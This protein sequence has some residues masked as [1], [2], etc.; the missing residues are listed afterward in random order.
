VKLI[1]AAKVE[2]LL[3]P[4][5]G[6]SDCG[7]DAG[8]GDS[9]RKDIRHRGLQWAGSQRLYER[10]ASMFSISKSRRKGADRRGRGGTK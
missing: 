5:T 4:G 9:K 6:Q 10:I 1:S 8:F 7:L 3:I 2:V